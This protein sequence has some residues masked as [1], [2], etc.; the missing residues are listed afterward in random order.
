METE[1]TL[2][3]IR[4]TSATR[5]RIRAISTTIGVVI[6]SIGLEVA[7]GIVLIAN[8]SSVSTY[9]GYNNNE[10]QPF[11]SIFSFIQSLLAV[12]PAAV[13]GM[14]WLALRSLLRHRLRVVLWEVTGLGVAFFLVTE[15]IT[16]TVGI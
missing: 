1:S 11:Y 8:I 15:V 6:A 5:R 10:P 14:Y 4:T 2:P 7:I 12:A 9:T 3:A 16:Y 13:G